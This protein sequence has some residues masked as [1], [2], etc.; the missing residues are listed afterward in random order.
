MRSNHPS[1]LHFVY[2][3]FRIPALVVSALA[4]MTSL[5]LMP[6]MTALQAR[7]FPLSL[8]SAKAANISE[9]EASLTAK[10]SISTYQW[11]LSDDGLPLISLPDH[12]GGGVDLSLT[13]SMDQF[14]FPLFQSLYY[15]EQAGKY[16]L[17]VMT[18][19]GGAEFIDLSPAEGVGLL[20]FTNNSNLRLAEKGDAKLISTSD[21]TVYTFAPFADGE[22]HCSQIK[23]HAGL[24]IDL[25]YTDAASLARIADTSGR[26]VNF[27]YTN[28]YLSSITQTWGP[29]VAKKKK[30]WA[31]SNDTP[32]NALKVNFAHAA[33]A[34]AKR[35]PTNAIRPNYTE[36]MAASDLTLATIFGGSGALAAGNGFEPA[37]LGSQYP[38][39]RGDLIGD[40]GVVRRGH[41][42][43]AMHLYG[44]PD[45][46]GGMGLY[47]PLGFI[48]HSGEPT[49]T[50]AAVTFYYP[51]LGNLTDV[52]LAVF[53]VANFC[54]T[55]EGERV[56]IGDIG[57]RGGSVAS[58]KH[59]HLEFYR[60]DTGLPAAAAR[61]QLRIDPDIV[62]G[63]SP[64]TVSR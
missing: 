55:P 59:S 50:D 31:I 63:S 11:N 47:V 40:D 10:Q 32:V 36:E 5:P 26:T 17:M 12:I 64:T 34:T 51:R 23:D 13:Y 24:V 28:H 52:T 37:G 38:L 9:S 57:G 33:P 6:F 2:R 14:Q 3:L 48:S 29:G 22:L 19:Q 18:A 20:Q 45:G 39:Y 61:A 56:R 53:H 1:R 7:V 43:Y 60:G 35:I 4:L 58:Y 27:S 15:N 30:T 8:A 46:T 54:L 44:S 21:G 16:I 42:S 49:P 62:F 25:K 41:L